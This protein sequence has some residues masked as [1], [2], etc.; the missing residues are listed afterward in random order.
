MVPLSSTNISCIS[1]TNIGAVAPLVFLDTH[2]AYFPSDLANH[3]KFTHP[4][5]NHTKIDYDSNLL[6]LDNLDSI[7]KL[8]GKDIFL[9]SNDDV[10]KL[11][12]YLRGNLPD[13]NTLKT[14]DAKSCAVIIA[15]KGN[16]M[17][18]AFYMYFYT[19]NQGPSVAGYE[20]GDHL[21]DW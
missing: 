5:V 18:D 20:L 14:V 3:L 9:T 21:G 19:F 6:T 15:D 2:D 10:T 8:G 1:I 7:N 17:M 4:E 13:S 16:D 11:P 12:E